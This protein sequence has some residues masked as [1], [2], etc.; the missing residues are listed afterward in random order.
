MP[1]ARRDAQDEIQARLDKLEMLVA[2]QAVTLDEM[3]QELLRAHDA[4]AQ[5]ERRHKALL[6]R[7]QDVEDNSAEGGAPR[8]EKPPHY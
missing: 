4:Q 7:L 8:H 6:S 3:S 5:L 1:T 2:H